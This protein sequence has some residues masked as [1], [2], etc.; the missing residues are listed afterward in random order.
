MRF[1]NEEETPELTG[2]DP[3]A[4][5]FFT[6]AAI[7]LIT[8]VSVGPE[9]AKPADDIRAAVA[10]TLGADPDDFL[11]LFARRSGAATSLAPKQVVAADLILTDS[12]L[13]EKIVKAKSA[14][15]KIALIVDRNGLDVAFQLESLLG[16]LGVAQLAQARM[17]DEAQTP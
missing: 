11:F 2:G 14:H 12:A 7:A 13:R 10:E 17:F 5:I 3:F 9:S 16:D 8:L 6:L 15:K 1:R 4:D